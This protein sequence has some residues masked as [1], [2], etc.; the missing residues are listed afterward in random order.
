MEKRSLSIRG[1]LVKRRLQAEIAAATGPK[2]GMCCLRPFYYLAICGTPGG[3]GVA[4]PC[5]P[6]YIR[7]PLGFVSTGADIDRVWNGPTARLYRKAMVS[8]RLASVCLQK[9]CP[10]FMNGSLPRLTGDTLDMTKCGAELFPPDLRDD[11]AV[12]AAVRSKATLLDYSPRAVVLACDSRCNLACSSCRSARVKNLSPAEAAFLDEVLRYLYRIGSELLELEMSGSG[13]V[14]YSP[15]SLQLLRSLNR[16]SFPKMKIHIVTN[17]QLLTPGLW[18]SLGEGKTFIGRIDVSVDAATKEVYESIRAGGRWE[19]L[20]E[21]LDFIS[22]LRRANAVSLFALNF[23]VSASNFREIGRF[24]E[25]G[26]TVGADLIFLTH[27]QDWGREMRYHYEREAVHLST[28]P[29]HDEYR[30]A[31]KHTSGLKK[32][33][34]VVQATAAGV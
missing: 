27:L 12:K 2:T 15:F 34:L 1:R 14:F 26:E 31:L 19:R 16:S 3:N 25:L 11:A 17:G 8:S 24:M 29:L 6:D 32:T 18:E 5:C 9:K 23:V 20:R 13:E 7:L 33:R 30:A 21:N 22:A 28:H 4:Y 10:F